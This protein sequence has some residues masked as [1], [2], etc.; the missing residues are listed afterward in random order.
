[1]L[2]IAAKTGV[3]MTVRVGLI[4]SGVMGAQHARIL[5]MDV[6]D[7]TLAAIADVDAERARRAA[8]PFDVKRIETDPLAVIRDANVDAVL[9][10]SS[11]DTHFD[12]VAECIRIGKPVLC[13]KP[14]SLT[15]VQC[16]ALVDAETKARKRLVQV[17]F[18]RRFD[19]GYAA[20]KEAVDDRRYGAPVFMHCVHRIAT[21]PHYFKTEVIPF[22]SAVHEFDAARYVLAE[23][24]VRLTVRPARAS[25]KASSRN[26]LFFL[27]EAASG[28]LVDVE[29][30]PDAQYGYDVRAELVLETGTLSLATPTATKIRANAYEGQPIDADW[31][32]RFALAYQRQASAWI[33]SILTTSSALAASAWDG[34]V[35]TTL[36]ELS[37]KALAE[38][39]DLTLIPERVPPLY[40]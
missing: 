30:F 8:A 16:R 29:I 9:V 2:P 26:P 25:A 32:R 24:F 31:S 33:R 21:A 18:M 12:L 34:Y 5:A 14:L 40:L 20:L 36:A 6:R 11:D 35:A 27:L 22:A 19:P 4:G 39:R 1:V 37:L 3:H 15:S 10:A 17:G 7:C 13:E 38:N 28:A 23:E